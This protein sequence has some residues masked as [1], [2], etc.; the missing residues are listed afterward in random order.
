MALIRKEALWGPVF[1]S[2]TI[3]TIGTRPLASDLDLH[4]HP[5]EVLV[6]ER[7]TN[8]GIGTLFLSYLLFLRIA[9][10]QLLSKH[11][12]GLVSKLPDGARSLHSTIVTTSSSP[13]FE[14]EACWSISLI[15][16]CVD[17]KR[18]MRTALY[19]IITEKKGRRKRLRPLEL[20]IKGIRVSELYKEKNKCPVALSNVRQPF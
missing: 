20:S 17:K 3:V 16:A 1:G 2:A 11:L 12:G 6:F 9:F 10:I 5:S 15:G 18:Y 4:I 8:S 19:N 14:F 13:L 7:A